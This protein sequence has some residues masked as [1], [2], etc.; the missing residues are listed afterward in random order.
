MSAMSRQY[1]RPV[2]IQISEL[3]EANFPMKPDEFWDKTELL[4]NV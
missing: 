2:A 3:Y 4:I 1:K